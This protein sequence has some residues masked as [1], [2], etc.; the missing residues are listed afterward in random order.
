MTAPCP[1]CGF[2]ASDFRESYNWYC[3]HCGK[4][5]AGWLLAQKASARP[6]KEDKENNTDKKAPFFSRREVPEEAKPVKFAELLIVL[7]ILMLLALNTAIE[8]VSSWLFPVS[9]PFVA[10]YAWTIY[11]TGYAIGQHQVYQ[12]DKNPLI[13]RAYLWGAIGFIF[14]ALFAWLG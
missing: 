12:R 9:I 11:K 3:T 10:Y 7:A 5:Y 6:E 13:Y 8:G 2:E 1:F 4:D 14:L